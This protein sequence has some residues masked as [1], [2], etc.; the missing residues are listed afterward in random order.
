MLR[1]DE[2]LAIALSLAMAANKAT[3]FIISGESK[4]AIPWTLVQIHRKLEHRDQKEPSS[5]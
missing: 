5:G 3:K 4:P 1:N 2:D